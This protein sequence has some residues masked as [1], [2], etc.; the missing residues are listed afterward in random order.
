MLRISITGGIACGKSTVGALM[1]EAGIAVCDADTVA[2]GL[3][4]RGEEVFDK[5]VQLFGP[6]ILG[7]DGEIDRRTLADRVFRNSGERDDHGKGGR[8]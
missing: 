5:I 8:T 4:R 3:M 1:A 2:H 7:E 6:R